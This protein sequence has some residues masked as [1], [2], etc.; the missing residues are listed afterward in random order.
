MD[1]TV[2]VNE[3]QKTWCSLGGNQSN[4]AVE[5]VTIGY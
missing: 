3:K 5:A 1:Q 2:K 4:M